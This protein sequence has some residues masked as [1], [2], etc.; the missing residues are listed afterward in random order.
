MKKTYYVKGM[1]CASCEKLIKERFEQEK[2]IKRISFSGS[3]IELEL[4]KPLTQRQLQQCLDGTEYTLT[5]RR[6]IPYKEIFI[7]VV[8]VLA[9]YSI[10]KITNLESFVNLS[11]ITPSTALLMGIFA[12]ISTC[13]AVTGGVVLA[14]SSKL[15]KFEQTTFHAIFNITRVATFTTLGFAL[16]YIGS[17]FH[18]NPTVS[19][20]ITFILAVF[21]IIIGLQLLSILPPILRFGVDSSFLSQM[22]TSSKKQASITG[23]A[24]FFFPCGFT[25]A[26]QLYAMTTGNPTLS[27]MLLLFFAIG[28]TPALLGIGFIQTTISGIVR[29]RVNAIAA[30]IIVVIGISLLLPSATLL[31]ITLPS[32]TS[33]P[34]GDITPDMFVPVVDGYQ[35]VKM[36]VDG[37]NYIPH[38]FY[39]QKDIPVKWQIDGTRAI[40]C[41]RV[42]MAPRL[43]ITE[44]VGNQLEIEFTP[45]QT[46]EIPFHCGMAMTRP[47]AKFIVV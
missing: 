33:T 35:I 46:G 13:L 28:S 37:I 45:T 43:G 5:T 25:Q 9:I 8:L 31:G 17:F 41:T 47:D 40:G 44:M 24:S 30:S 12:S 18:I 36:S 34:V 11:Q 3:T 4:K 39:L 19:G 10:M 42:I 16:G 23:V 7:G 21:L 26:L 20:L 1:H 15:P 32:S 38:Q 22:N 14:L 2:K 6:E 29:Q 27:A